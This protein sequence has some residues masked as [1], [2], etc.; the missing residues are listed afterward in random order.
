M[1]D[2]IGWSVNLKNI[3]LLDRTGVFTQNDL[4]MEYNM[5]FEEDI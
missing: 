4:F 3:I 5:R 1:S 2:L